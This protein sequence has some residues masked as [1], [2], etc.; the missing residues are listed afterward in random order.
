MIQ[1]ATGNEGK[2]REARDYLPANVRQVDY[3]YR[4]IQAAA[5]E[6]IARHGAAETVR[7]TEGEDPVIVED[8]GLFIEALDGFPG[9]YSAYVEDTLG[10]EQM[11]AL[12]EESENTRAAFRSVV[13]YATGGRLGPL[14][15]MVDGERTILDDVTVVTFVGAV[16]GDIVDP[17]GDGGF[18]YDPVFEYDGTTL[19]E[20]S[21]AEKNAISHRGRALEKLADFLSAQED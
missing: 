4:E 13:A 2:L 6:P 20:M 21:T 11:P 1:F 3:D 12:L 8:S 14:P 9:P 18:G 17:R 16:Q 7:E 5:L 10:I 15:E 19:A